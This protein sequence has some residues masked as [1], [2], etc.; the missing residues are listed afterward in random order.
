MVMMVDETCI[1]PAG[2]APIEKANAE[3][4]QLAAAA[5]SRTPVARIATAEATAHSTPLLVFGGTGTPWL[6]TLPKF[7]Q[8]M[9]FL[10][11]LLE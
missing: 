7:N 5:A 9:G 10:I 11:G 3:T 4:A 8:L 6:S 1:I 2:I